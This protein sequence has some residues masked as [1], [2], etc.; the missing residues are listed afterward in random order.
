MFWCA[1]LASYW[2]I[3]K[4]TDINLNPKDEA[5]GRDGVDF[6]SSQYTLTTFTYRKYC[7]VD[8]LLRAKHIKMCW[9]E[10]KWG[11]QRYLR[12][13]SQKKTFPPSGYNIE[14]HILYEFLFITVIPLLHDYF[15]SINCCKRKSPHSLTPLLTHNELNHFLS[16]IS[17]N[18]TTYYPKIN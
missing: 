7:V 1:V 16:T 15:Y 3:G 17:L 14:M 8:F 10:R 2:S 4:H 6:S 12:Q 11:R 9:A 13:V 5:V 18:L